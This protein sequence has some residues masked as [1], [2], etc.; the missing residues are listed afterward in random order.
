MFVFSDR[1]EQLT[2]FDETEIV[3]SSKNFPCVFS[4]TQ[5]MEEPKMST[6]F[7]QLWD[8]RVW[9]RGLFWSWNLIFLAVLLLGYAPLIVPST[10][11][12]V[13]AGIIPL[14]FLLVAVMLVL[15]PIL[16]IAIA[17]FGL[18]HTPERLFAFAYSIEWPL[19][20]VLILRF[21]VIRDATSVV[22]WVIGTGLVGMATLLW[23]ILDRAIDTRGTILTLARAIGLTFL[24]L[25]YLYVS[26]WIAFYA[27]PLAVAMV[28]GIIELA[29]S[30]LR[31]LASLD[32][33]TI[34]MFFSSSPFILMGGVLLAYTASLFIVTPIAVPILAIRAWWR[35][36]QSLGARINSVRASVIVAT[37]VV[38]W[39]SAFILTNRQ[40]QRDAFT[41]LNAPP[42][43]LAEA[44]AMMQQED[45]LRAG[46]LNT[47]LAQ[48]RYISAV[49]EVKHI[50]DL[51][52]STLGFSQAQGAVIE[53]LYE[54]IAHPLLYEPVNPPAA[55]NFVD[56]RALREEPAQAEKLYKAYFD[57]RIVDNERA[58]IANAV[59]STWSASQAEAA[60]LA[61]DD[62]EIHLMRQ[63]VHVTEH[64]D[65]AE[66]EVYEVYQNQTTQRQEVVYYFSLPES[67]VVTG[68]WL[69][70]SDDRSQRFVYHVSPRGA[71]QAVYRN[72][73][74]RNMDPALLEQIGPRQYRLRIFP[75]PARTWRSDLVLGTVPSN[76]AAPMHVWF[77]F[78]VLA[79]NN[80]WPMPRLAESRNIYWDANTLRTVN[81][82]PNQVDA[83]S[84]LPASIPATTPVQ[85]TS[86]RV[87]FANGAVVVARP[88]AVNDLPKLGNN[89]RVAIVQDRSRSMAKYS[90]EVKQALAL[91]K[92]IGTADV[93]LTASVYRGEKASRTNLNALDV[94]HIEYMGGQ[95]AG[96]L[97][98]QFDALRANDKYDAIFV[99]TDGTGYELGDSGFKDLIPNAPLWMVH[100][101]G[102]LPLGYD[103]ATLEAIQASGGGVTGSVQEALNRLAV[104][105]YPQILAQNDMPM[106]ATLDWVD[107]YVWVTSPGTKSVTASLSDEFAPFAARRVILDE[108]YRNRGNLRQLTTLDQLH[109]IAIKQSIVTPFSSMLVLVNAQQEAL[110]KQLETNGDRFDREVEQVGDTVPQAAL[111]VTGVPEPHE[112]LLMAIGAAMLGWY[113]YKN[114]LGLEQIRSRVR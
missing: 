48:F 7:R 101:G 71:A 45:T 80:A 57:A 66:V 102:A 36:V 104:T 46:L 31:I 44:R 78:R 75:I 100:L 30:F 103:D 74:R 83:Q 62:R 25:V 41:L 108:M 72:E 98:A 76:D 58:T 32:W 110:L 112:W 37:V 114:R 16:S 40:P 106:G 49:G 5:G 109:A 77:T 20:F 73:V 88:L 107:G 55:K 95:N 70:N 3:E 6:L 19:M 35:G 2:E 52:T 82:K 68:V 90:T 26:I 67:A 59:R 17:L 87:E 14:I 27:F 29:S 89:L 12:A 85:L 84:W 9:A 92:T 50:S 61:V 99:I 56:G 64:G 10:I 113:V 33:R 86:H 47:F 79:Q 96:E 81:G 1:V 43:T 28:K 93:Y 65:W 42:A 11:A 69:G 105:L 54:T 94:D 97:L 13:I 21:F 4:V 23:Q 53:L 24:L 39:V 60:W 63:A 15:I 18:R 91:L 8:G 51:Y 22:D 111:N 34:A 38:L